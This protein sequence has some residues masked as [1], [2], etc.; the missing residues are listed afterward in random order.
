VIITLANIGLWICIGV[1]AVYT[2]RHYFFTL[3]RLFGRHRQP[4]V[5]IIQADWPQMT[6]FVPAHNEGRVIR[7]SLD[8]LLSVDYPAERLRIVPIDDRPRTTREIMQSTLTR[9]PI[10]SSRICATVAHRAKR[11]RL[12]KR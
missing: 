7:D 3:N 2:V 1:L 10:A 5:D 4:Y 8:A 9:I 6:V 11:R 12:P